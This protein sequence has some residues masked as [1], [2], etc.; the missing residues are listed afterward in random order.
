MV[1]ELLTIAPDPHMIPCFMANARTSR[2]NEICYAFCITYFMQV[3]IGSSDDKRAVILW[4]L[5][6]TETVIVHYVLSS[7]W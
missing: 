1:M 7:L 2:A 6:A 4:N 5:G 3:R